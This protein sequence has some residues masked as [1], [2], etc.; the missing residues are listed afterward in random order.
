TE[1]AQQIR[2]GIEEHGATGVWDYATRLEAAI[3]QQDER[4]ILISARKYIQHPDADAFELGSTLR[5]LKDVWRL[6]GTDIGKKL[7]PVLE[8]AVLQRAGGAGHPLPLGQRPRE[9]GAV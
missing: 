6:E 3:A 1:I 8:Y 7:L 9:A 5:Q 4:A 2:G